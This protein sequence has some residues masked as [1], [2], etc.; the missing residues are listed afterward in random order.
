[1]YVILCYKKNS[2]YNIE[3]NFYFE[4]NAMKNKGNRKT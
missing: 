3:L 2:T 4:I 1:M